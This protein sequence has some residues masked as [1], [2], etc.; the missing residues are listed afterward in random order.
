M[1]ISR[2]WVLNDYESDTEFREI[3]I[4]GK[5]NPRLDLKVGR[6]IV[7]WGKS[8]NFRVV[9]VLNPPDL[10]EPGLV[11]IENLRLPSCK[12]RLDYYQGD[13]SLSGLAIHEIRFDKLPP[14]GS[15]FYPFPV[16][17]PPVMLC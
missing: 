12:S 6:Q 7:V 13:W 3:F 17:L 14:Y 2:P 11:D 15:D 10:R 8:D 4:R 16:K 1:R 5:I 9:D